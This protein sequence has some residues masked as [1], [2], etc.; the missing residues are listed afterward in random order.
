MIN[1]YLKLSG[2]YFTIFMLIIT[3]IYTLVG[4]DDLLV[5]HTIDHNN[6]VEINV[7]QSISIDLIRGYK[8]FTIA[9]FGLYLFIL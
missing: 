7:Y 6:T 8:Y 2:L 3:I 4:Y 9:Y 1:L 5:N